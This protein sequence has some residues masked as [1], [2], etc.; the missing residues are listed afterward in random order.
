MNDDTK[1]FFALRGADDE[2]TLSMLIDSFGIKK[3]DELCYTYGSRPLLCLVSER[4]YVDLLERLLQSGELDVNDSDRAN[5]TPLDDVM[6][7]G[8]AYRYIISINDGQY[9]YGEYAYVDAMKQKKC[10]L[11]ARAYRCIQLLVKFG[12]D[13]TIENRSTTMWDDVKI[14]EYAAHESFP[15][16]MERCLS[17]R[18]QIERLALFHNRLLPELVSC[19]FGYLYFHF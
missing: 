11:L 2:V 17:N 8:P 13:P 7:P 19:V 16:E 14:G 5:S 12:A 10:E 15:L 3:S 9:E 1:S 6:R 4:W 18:R